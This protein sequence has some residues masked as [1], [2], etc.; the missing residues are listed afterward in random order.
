MYT[1]SRWTSCIS[2][3]GIDAELCKV[4]SRVLLNAA[5]MV[6]FD[7]KLAPRVQS[8]WAQ[9]LLQLSGSETR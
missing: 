5:Q 9:Y 3:F 1:R 7:V 8:T 2:P 6:R 4:L